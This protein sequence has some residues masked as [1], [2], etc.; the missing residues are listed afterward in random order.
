MAVR[1]SPPVPKPTK[2]LLPKK[3][4]GESPA[5]ASAPVSVPAPPAPLTLL[6]HWPRHRVTLLA[7]A[8][9]DVLL[10]CL[11]RCPT[12]TPPRH[13]L[14]RHPAGHAASMAPCIAT[15]PIPLRRQVEA[16]A[17]TPA[18]PDG[19]GGGA[20]EEG[21]GSVVR[22]GLQEEWRGRAAWERG[23]K[24]GR[25]CRHGPSHHREAG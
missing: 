22:K 8:A 12:T 11:H 24:G 4:Q 23:G 17:T 19:D 14:A 20:A 13:C 10:C 7:V 1:A 5:L 3:N 9:L 2:L 15:R 16:E 6:S 18:S 21:R 25:R